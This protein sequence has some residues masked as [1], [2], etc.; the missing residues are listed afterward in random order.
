[1]A[2]GLRLPTLS[3]RR[4]TLVLLCLLFTLAVAPVAA[5]RAP[6]FVGAA[7]D[8]AKQPDPAVAKAKMDLAKLAGFDAIRITALWTPAKRR[9]E[10]Y[11]L[12]TLGNAAAAAEL[13]G[14]RLIVAVYPAGSSVTPMTVLA[15]AQFAAWTASIARKLPY[16]KDFVVGN[17]PNLNRFWMPQFTRRGTDAAAPAYEMLLARTYDALKAV[18]PDIN[19]I[20]GAVS[21]H[22]SDDPKS[23]RPTHSPTRF[24]LD[25]GQFYRGTGRTLPIMDAFVLHPYLDSSRQS[26]SFQHVTSTS[27]GIGDYSKL[28]SLLGQAF[29]GTAQPGSKLPVLYGEFGVQ[30]RIAASKLRAYSNLKVRHPDAI[31][32]AAQAA[33]YEAALELAACQ[34]N[35][36]GLL[37]F[38]VSDEPNLAAWQSGVYYA[39]DTPK[40]SL[41]A[42]RAAIQ[43]ALGGTLVDCSAKSRR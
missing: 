23:I 43:A 28:V 41:P 33:S 19:V 20:G 32:E 26:P 35:V 12:L 22:G 15:R 18:S 5:A 40:S 17:E 13:D 38:H 36:I 21:S 1:M 3:L 31:T 9:L 42:I 39:D 29:D 7:E 24:I 8:G 4:P 2:P 10:G 25:L 30:T 14:I 37:F 11:D 16:V 27:V 6:L 34:P